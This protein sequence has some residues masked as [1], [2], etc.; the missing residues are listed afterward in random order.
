MSQ[1]NR[2]A[3]NFNSTKPEEDAMPTI[4]RAKFRCMSVTKTWDHKTE[5]KLLPVNR[6]S[7]KDPENQKFWDATP[8]GKAELYF[9]GHRDEWVPGDYYYIDHEAA[10]EGLWHLGT[11]SQYP[12]GGSE[13]KLA[14]HWSNEHELRNGTLDM[15]IQYPE[16][17]AL[18]G[19]PGSRWDV[20]FTHAEVT[21]NDPCRPC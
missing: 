8:G 13:V 12:D 18:F 6:S 20:T 10:P 4:I 5:V 3:S 9:E 14:K 21:D 11:V 17:T 15:W 7:S 16:T 2:T 1:V 19:K